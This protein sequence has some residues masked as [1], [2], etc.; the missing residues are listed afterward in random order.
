[1][2]ERKKLPFG[3]VM[4]YLSPCIRSMNLQM[5]SALR[6]SRIAQVNGPPIIASTA[7]NRQVSVTA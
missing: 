1:V 2:V 3:K 4:F 6:A 5:P 7:R